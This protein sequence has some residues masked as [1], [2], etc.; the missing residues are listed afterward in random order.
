MFFLKRSISFR[1]LN[2]RKIAL[3]LKSTQKISFF[4]YFYDRKFI[5]KILH[6]MIFVYKEKF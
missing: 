6:R 5:E 2:K 4:Y 3:I 1:N